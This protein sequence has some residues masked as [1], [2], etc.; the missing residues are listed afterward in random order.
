MDADRP[1]FDVALCDLLESDGCGA[2]WTSAARSARRSAGA[3]VAGGRALSVLFAGSFT[4]LIWSGFTKTS[5]SPIPRKPPTASL[6]FLT[7]LFL[8]FLGSGRFIASSKEERPATNPDRRGRTARSGLLSPLADGKRQRD[9]LQRRDL[10]AVPSQHHRG[11][12]A[13]AAVAYSARAA[14][15]GAQP[16]ALHHDA[17]TSGSS[18]MTSNCTPR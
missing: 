17:N 15:P 6:T 7:F 4:N 3:L 9:G 2:P 13:N 18:R 14:S 10:T 5:C 11:R 16:F 1:A 8:T 12:F